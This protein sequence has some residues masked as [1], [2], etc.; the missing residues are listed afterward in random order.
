MQMWRIFL[1]I[2]SDIFVQVKASSAHKGPYDF[3]LL[4]PVQD[5]KGEQNVSPHINILYRFKF[6]MTCH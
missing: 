5:L 2:S 3:E 6:N 1:L 4:V